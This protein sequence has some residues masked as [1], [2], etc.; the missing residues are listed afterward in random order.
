MQ[1]SRKHEV[2][3][4]FALSGK[5]IAKMTFKAVFHFNRIVAKRSVFLFFVNTQAEL[6]M[7]TQCII[8]YVWLRYG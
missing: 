2:C 7:W 3:N 4:R 8:R 1:I 6:I 5:L